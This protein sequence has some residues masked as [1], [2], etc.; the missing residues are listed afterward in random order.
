LK[1]LKAVP[2]KQPRR[3][4]GDSSKISYYADPLIEMI[5]ADKLTHVEEIT[6]FKLFPSYSFTRVYQKGEELKA[7]VDRPACEISLT[8]H[9]ATVGKQWPIWMQAPGGEPTEYT[10]EPGDACVYKGCEIKHWRKPATDTDINVQ[11]MLHYVNQNG[12]CAGYKYD[13]R[14]GL[15]LRK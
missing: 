13:Q 10:L 3:W 8:C 2:R 14:P 7:H 1:T 11:M 9:I 4:Q 15:S 5:L 6:G 12:P